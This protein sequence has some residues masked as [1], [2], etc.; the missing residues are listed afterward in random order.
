MGKTTV[1]EA[2]ASTPIHFPT[3]IVSTIMLRDITKI[4]IEAGT[5]CLISSLLIFCVPK[6]FANS[7]IKQGKYQHIKTFKWMGL[8]YLG[9]S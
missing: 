6:S 8:N 7:V 2:I 1:T 3:K 9:K 5:A 4:P